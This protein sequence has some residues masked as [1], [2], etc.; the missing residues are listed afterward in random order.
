MIYKKGSLGIEFSYILHLLEVTL[1]Q[2]SQ[3]S[4][5]TFLQV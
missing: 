5:A 4:G 1:I 2:G 3:V